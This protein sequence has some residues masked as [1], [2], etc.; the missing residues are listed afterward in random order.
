M[1]NVSKLA[2]LR[3]AILTKAATAEQ[4]AEYQALCKEVPEGALEEA[5]GWVASVMPGICNGGHHVAH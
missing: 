3:V 4:A 5:E 1:K 2:G